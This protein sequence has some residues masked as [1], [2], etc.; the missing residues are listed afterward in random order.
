MED[1]ALG[2]PPAAPQGRMDPIGKWRERRG[3]AGIV[4]I[5]NSRSEPEVESRDQM[6]TAAGAHGCWRILL[7]AHIAANAHSFCCTS[8]IIS[9]KST[10]F[11]YIYLIFSF[12]CH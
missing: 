1:D 12:K 6:H 11:L 3:V 9:T 5:G 8:Y 10:F 7:P 2:G 4:L